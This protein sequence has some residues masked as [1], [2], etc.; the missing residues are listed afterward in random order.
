MIWSF[1][2]SRTFAKCQ[3]RWY[4][5]ALLAWWTQKDARRWEAYL[6]SKLQ[7]V[8]AWRGQI[9][10]TAISSVLV[11]AL[12]RRVPPSLQRCL[13]QARHLFDVQRSFALNHRL[14]ENGM[15]PSRAG[16]A[17]AA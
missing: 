4:Y 1:S 3:R 11:P 10:D 5:D 2:D 17:F 7:S 9:V 13:E 14:R 8:S 6:L 16:E 12:N 15:V